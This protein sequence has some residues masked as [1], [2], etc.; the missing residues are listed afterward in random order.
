METRRKVGD[1]SISSPFKSY[2]VV[3]K[4]YGFLKMSPLKILFKSY[5]VVWKPMFSPRKIT[6]IA[7]LNR[8]M[9]YGNK[10]QYDRL[11]TRTKVFKSYYVVWK[12]YVMKYV[13][14]EF[15]KFKSYYVV[16]KPFFFSFISGEEK[17]LNR[18][19]QYGNQKFQIVKAISL[20]V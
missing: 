4:L 18:T 7:S 13:T 14:K 15:A 3:W 1:P 6:N 11:L 5:Y 10:S 2:Y 19:M 9:Q 20:N 8:T 12:P 16:W 17:S